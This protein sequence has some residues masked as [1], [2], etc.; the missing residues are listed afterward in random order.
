MKKSY[1]TSIPD[2]IG[3]FLKASECFAQLGINITRVS[4]N[5]A[6]DSHKLFVDVEGAPQKLAEA[7][8]RL[9]EIGYLGVENDNSGI[10]LL[11]FSL[12]DR[13]GSMAAVLRLIKDYGLNI[14]YMSY[15]DDGTRF[16]DCKMGLYFESEDRLKAFI[17]KARSVCPVRVL[18][19]D[20]TERVFDN[21]IFYESFVSD[22]IKCIGLPDSAR[23]ELLLNSNLVMQMLDEKGLSPYRTFESISMV[24]RLLEA[25]RGSGFYPRISRHSI[26]ENTEI[27]LIEP[28]C[29][30]NTAI[31]K[32]CGQVLFVDTGYALY[33]EET[34][35]VYRQVLPEYDSIKKTAY[36][37]HADLDH[38]GQLSLFDEVLAGE[39]TKRCLQL[40]AEG[41]DAFRESNPLHKP[42]IKICKALTLYEPPEP[43][44]IKVLWKSPETIEDPLVHVGT[45]DLGELHF[46]AYQGKGGHLKG[47]TVLIDF[48]HR[49]VFPGDIYVNVHGQIKEQTEYNSYAPVLMTSVDTDPTL[50]AAERAAL[51]DIMGPGAWQV[52]GAHGMKKDM[53][54]D[55]QD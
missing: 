10:A 28:P 19:Y 15:Q 2:H 51:M 27:I 48:V 9:K 22:L 17:K 34:E 8:E 39:D 41:R 36:I 5:K 40:E 33:K 37:T 50:C 43:G 29:G 4:Y 21:S 47:E 35:R 6:V 30:S 11:D 20:H 49:L 46:D 53:Y 18:D 13:P 38:C 55:S 32:S 24:A 7:D 54:I 42:Y 52:F 16:Q 25:S 23:S 3:A 44:R 1:I 12:E 31:I 45:F 14:S 26:T